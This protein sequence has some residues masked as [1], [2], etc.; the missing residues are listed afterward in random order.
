MDI[1]QVFCDASGSGMGF[2]YPS[3]NLGF[4]S[5]LPEHPL[6]KDI[7]IFFYKALCIA[8]AIHDAVTH[9]PKNG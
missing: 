8:S 5:N 2:W 1:L 9:L 4:Q 3:L 6:M 7:F